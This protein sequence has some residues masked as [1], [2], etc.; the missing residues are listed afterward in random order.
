M[1]QHVFVPVHE[2]QLFTL[3]F[4]QQRPPYTPT[5][6]SLFRYSVFR[7]LQAPVSIM[8]F[9]TRNEIHRATD[10]IVHGECP[11]HYGIVHCDIER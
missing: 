6:I 5:F 4:D 10:D 3:I 11:L 1:V 9:T 8:I 7:V 2:L